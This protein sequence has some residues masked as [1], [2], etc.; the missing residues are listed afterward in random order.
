MSNEERMELTQARAVGCRPLD[1]LEEIG[2]AFG[3]SV[4]IVA[5]VYWSITLPILLNAYHESTGEWPRLEEQ[6]SHWLK[7]LFLFTL[8]ILKPL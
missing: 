3:V 7:R 5:V 4:G 6:A 8:N 1:S 2:P